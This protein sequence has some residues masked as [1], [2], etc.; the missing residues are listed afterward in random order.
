MRK[1]FVPGS[2]TTLVALD[3]L[4]MLG[5]MVALIAAVHDRLG[6]F[7]LAETSLVI[8]TLAVSSIA[9]AYAS[10]CYRHDALVNFSTSITRLV[11]ALGVGAALSLALIHFGFSQLFE[12]LAFRSAS[13]GLTIVLVGTSAELFGGMIA[14]PLFLAMARRH[15]FRRHILVIGTGIR[16]H[17]LRDLFRRSDRR[18]AELNFVSEEYLGGVPATNLPGEPIVPLPKVQSVEE[19]EA[20]LHIDQ[21]VVAVDDPADLHFDH[22]LPWK[23][24]GVPVF[25]FNT[26]IE[27]ETGRVDLKWTE[28][29]WLL[30]SEGFR[31]GWLDRAIKRL[32]DIAASASLL[33]LTLPTL[34]VIAVAIVFEDFGPVFYRQER[35]SRGGRTFKIIKFRT[36][37]VDA[38]KFGAQW[39]SENDPRVT[40]VGR[41]LRRTR[42]DEIPQLINVLTGEMS[43]VG[44]RPERPV[45]VN[46]LSEQI[47]LYHLRHCVKAGVTGWAQINYPYGASVE[48]AMRKLEYDLFYLKHF[49]V[50]RDLSIM[51]QTFRVLVF[52][53]GS[54]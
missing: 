3:V 52:A 17:Y 42:I 5:S 9:F 1:R 29:H 37:R 27:R 30:Y 50:L 24:N 16:A 7:T 46:Q 25:D 22:L 45:F 32:L 48:D 49:S 54:R 19:L 8:A 53:Q 34:A 10:G 39:A 21:V 38:E 36:M 20:K 43:M 35:V 28:S 26:F 31:F 11:V 18:L 4:F 40:R 15:W 2:R 51:L 47:R 23:A 44:P 14:R 13:R 41:I 33:L 12:T 6:L